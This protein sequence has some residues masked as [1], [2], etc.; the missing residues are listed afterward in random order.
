MRSISLIQLAISAQLHSP[1]EEDS[2]N[3]GVLNRRRYY[4]LAETLERLKSTLRARA[5]TVFADVDHSGEAEKVGLKMPPR[6]LVIVRSAKA[7]TPLIAGSSIRTR[8]LLL[9]LECCI[10]GN[11]GLP[12]LLW[13][14]SFRNPL[15]LDCWP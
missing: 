12:S 1:N 11:L 5:V 2:M 9:T 15:P 4:S 3:N 14:G 7:G 13:T 6:K 8:Y 10:I